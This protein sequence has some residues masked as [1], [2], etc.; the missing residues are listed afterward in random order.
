MSDKKIPIIETNETPDGQTA[1]A[2]PEMPKTGSDLG[3]AEYDLGD[4]SHL[5][6]FRTAEEAAAGAVQEDAGP[7]YAAAVDDAGFLTRDAW[8]DAFAAAFRIGGGATGLKTLTDAAGAD[9]LPPAAHA[10]YDAARETPYF[11][12]LIRPDSVW[13]QRAIA[14]SVFTIPVAAGC[15]RELKERRAA[16]AAAGVAQEET[17]TEAAALWRA[18]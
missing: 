6:D 14:I 10:I 15:G 5:D 16:S 18:K 9:S 7:A 11:H 1:A 17:D 2:T 3:S 4:G 8:T 12:W 13:L